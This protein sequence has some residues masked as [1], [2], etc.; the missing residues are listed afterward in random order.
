MHHLAY[1]FERFPSFTQTFCAR[2]ILELERQGLKPLIFSIHDVSDEEVHHFPEEL[3]K[4]VHTLPSEKELVK[5]ISQLK[6]ERKLP[7]SVVLTLREWERG[8]DKARVYEAAYIGLKMEEAGV[9]HAHSHFAGLGART[10]WWLRQFYQFTYSFTGH[11][12]DMFVNPGLPITLRHLVRDASLVVTVSDYTAKWLRQE[13]PSFRRKVKR[14]YNGLDL[15]SISKLTIGQPKEMPPLIFSVGR[16]IEKKGFDDLVRACAKL[17]DRG[18]NFQCAIAGDGPLEGDLQLLIRSFEL[19]KQVHLVGPKSQNEIKRFLGGTTVF[20]LPCVTEK[21]GGK[22][23]LPTVLMEAMA[24]A[25]PCVSTNLAGVPEMVI[26]EETGLLCDER[27]PDYFASN[28]QK[29]LT[30]PALAKKYGEAGL[31]RAR[32]LFEQQTTA[33]QLM[34]LL[35]QYGDVPKDPQLNSPGYRRQWPWKF[36]RWIKSLKKPSKQAI[37]P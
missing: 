22:D 29:V 16:L 27:E 17:R 20:A 1:V 8:P 36:L 15:A 25:L 35:I 24:A 23:N 30:N 7:Q 19:V 31:K 14:V 37:K 21:C 26:H 6:D 34:G 13:F 3:K 10:C 28:L 18:V 4:R 11:A 32:E 9:R 33:A 5:I 2:E 12:N